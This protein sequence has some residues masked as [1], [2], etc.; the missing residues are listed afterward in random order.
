MTF[1]MKSK[2]ITAAI[3]SVLLVGCDTSD[4]IDTPP[5]PTEEASANMEARKADVGV[6]KQGSAMRGD[7]SLAAKMVTSSARAY[8]DMKEDIV[9]NIQLKQAMQLFKAQDNFGKG[10]QSHEEYMQKIVKANNITLPK[11]PE[12][13][14]YIY[15]PD[16]EEL[17][18]EPIE[19]SD[20]P[21]P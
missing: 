13:M 9:F 14:R 21:K 15:K 11:L 7:D 8:F 16:I 3:L 17:W 19:Q 10:P 2:G 5:A 1:Q 4:S 12:G 18:V 20:A 6:G